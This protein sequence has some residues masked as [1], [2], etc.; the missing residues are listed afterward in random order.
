MALHAP[1][2]W[3]VHIDMRR[4][5]IRIEMCVCVCER[6]K[7]REYVKTRQGG[8]AVHSHPGPHPLHLLGI[9]AVRAGCMKRGVV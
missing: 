8:Y 5:T 1:L 2:G 6:D 9:C 4:F 7:E 3:G